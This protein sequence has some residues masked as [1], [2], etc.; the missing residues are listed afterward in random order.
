MKLKYFLF[1]ILSTL[2]LPFAPN[3]SGQW[4]KTNCPKEIDFPVIAVNGT[5][6]FAG[7][8]IG[9]FLSTDGGIEWS[10]ANNVLMR[11]DAISSFT[12]IGTDMFIGTWGPGNGVSLS[13]DS[14]MSWTPASAIM[15]N[16]G[17]LQSNINAVLAIGSYLFAGTDLGGVFLSTDSGTSWTPANNGLSASNF[18]LNVDKLFFSGSSIFAA[19]YSSGVGGI[20]R[21]MDSGGSW[22]LAS[23]GLPADLAVQAFA[24]LGANL[25]IGTLH[26]GVFRLSDNGSTWT[27]ANTGLLDTNI[28]ALGV[29]G[30]NLFAGTQSNGV[31]LSTNNGASWT[32]VSTGI[33]T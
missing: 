19:A 20:F 25:F 2:S 7:S 6:I 17:G 4:I 29:S 18:G 22:I 31:F 24:V 12:T 30:E 14:G 3:V 15:D 1:L 21:S 10:A 9:V 27:A 11:G 16:S 28:S 26:S 13:T 5:D 8:N 33:P 23:N 32:E